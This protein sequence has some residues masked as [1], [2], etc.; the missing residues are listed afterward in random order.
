MY[1]IRQNCFSGEQSDK[2]N[3]AQLAPEFLKEITNGVEMLFSAQVE[4]ST[5]GHSANEKKQAELKQL[6]A[7][8]THNDPP[9]NF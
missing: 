9:K 2:G 5:A 1:A 7:D 8:F 6:L 3:S 4:E